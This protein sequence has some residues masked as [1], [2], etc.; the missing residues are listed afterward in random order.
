MIDGPLA[1]R[2]EYAILE[3]IMGQDR[4]T[5]QASWGVWIQSVL[6]LVPELRH[7]ADL[8]AAFKRLRGT[9]RVRLSKADDLRY[10]GS[11]YSENES[12]DEAFFLTATFNATITADGREY[13][14]VIQ[15]KARTPIGF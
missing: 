13:W 7:D 2:L 1:Y 4:G 3:I 5:R 14:D 10:H 15:V 9:G 11:D 6:R 12:D 8:L